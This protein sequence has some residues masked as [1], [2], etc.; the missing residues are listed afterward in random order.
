[1]LTPLFKTRSFTPM[2]QPALKFQL[3]TC[4]Y[5]VLGGP[6]AARLVA[7]PAQAPNLDQLL[8][9]LRCPIELHTSA[10][11]V[12]WWGL[13]WSVTVQDGAVSAQITLDDLANRVRVAY[14]DMQPAASGAGTRQTSA[15]ADD[16]TSQAVYGIK[17]A[18][19]A[20][21]SATQAQAESFRATYLAASSRPTIRTGA[22]LF[23][24]LLKGGRGDSSFVIT[25]DC[26][27]WWDTLAWRS[28]S[29]PALSIENVNQLPAWEWDFGNTGS[30]E[31]VAQRVTIPAGGWFAGTIWLPLRRM[32]V[33]TSNVVVDLCADAG[34]VAPGAS[35]STAVY[36][37][38]SLPVNAYKWVKFQLAPGVALAAGNYW[39]KLSDSAPFAGS[40]YRVQVDQGLH[41]AAGQ[42]IVWNG[43]AWVSATPNADLQFR[44][45]CTLE[46][47]QQIRA[48][49]AAAGQF[50]TGLRLE[51]AS[52]LYT[53]PY[54][55]GDTHALEEI[56]RH[57]TA[58]S[59]TGLPLTAQVTP[60]R[61][62]AIKAKADP[63]LGSAFKIG[64][65]GIIRLPSGSPATPGPNLA[66][67]WAALDVPWSTTA[68]SW[69]L[70]PGLVYLDA[71]ECD[72]ATGWMRPIPAI[73]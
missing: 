3:E 15:W 16:L 19:L 58:G 2:L 52:G 10:G 72:G 14:S 26:R 34:G 70:T 65:D 41:Y 39:L 1:M 22:S 9:L 18:Q 27:G 25:L 7:R 21:S 59:I 45:G 11:R 56:T 12:A 23:A 55:S 36:P 28:Y 32:G 61:M 51:T 35:L 43:A 20:L 68:A 17:E 4:T 5:S 50:L 73:F 60:E 37:G 29:S 8:A 33:V 49:V 48:M 54:R 38:A 44:L 67:A 66:G 62:L 46:T 24:P 57:L 40:H 47:T 42:A 71:V 31:L 64:R 69:G 30:S 63:S 53:N 6:R 13:A